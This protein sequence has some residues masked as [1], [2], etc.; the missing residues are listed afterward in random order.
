M[1]DP[2]NTHTDSTLTLPDDLELISV[3]PAHLRYYTSLANRC[4]NQIGH[5]P[6]QA[7]AAYAGMG[8]LHYA[9]VNGDPIGLILAHRL[10]RQP[11]T[12][13]ILQAAI[14][15]DARRWHYGLAQL[16]AIEQRAIAA[17]VTQARLWCRQG[18]PAEHFWRFCGYQPVATREGG[19]RGKMLTCYARVFALDPTAPHPADTYHG[20]AARRWKPIPLFEQPQLFAPTT[21]VRARDLPR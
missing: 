12:L 3:D 5:L 11:H 2:L 21:A 19:K 13:S 9:S 17:G 16:R 1:K 20:S 18:L 6:T 8:E 7:V 10:A 4:C 14:Q 15:H